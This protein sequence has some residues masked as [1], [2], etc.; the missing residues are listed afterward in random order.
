MP[1]NITQEAAD[2]TRD[3]LAAILPPPGNGYYCVA[4]LSTKRK[5]HV[6][7]ESIDDVVEAAFRFNSAGRDTYYALSTFNERGNRTAANARYC[8]SLFIDIDCGNDKP[9]A[10]SRDAAVALAGFCEANTLPNPSV[11]R[12]GY[13]LHAYWPFTIPVPIQEWV[14]AAK[15]FKR[16]AEASNL[17][18]DYSV[19]ADSARVL[20]VPNTSNYK[21]AS[22][23]A[24][25]PVR[26]V[27]SG[28]PTPF[29]VFKEL[30]RQ[31]TPPQANKPIPSSRSV[32]GL[33]TDSIPN[34]AA[35]KD[36]AVVL[37]L[38]N[39]TKHSFN[40]IV[41]LGDAGCGQIN[42]YLKNA[43]EGGMEPLWRGV[44]STIKHCE[45]G[46]DKALEVSRLHPY[47]D[48]RTAKKY[49]GIKGPY[50]CE[51]FAQTNPGI[52]DKCIHKS[53]IVNPIVLGRALKTQEEVAAVA[54]QEPAQNTS[55]APTTDIF[56]F[57]D[58]PKG[59]VLSDRG[60]G[61]QITD[62]GGVPRVVFICDAPVFATAT[63][64]RAGERYVQFS[65]I[66]HKELKSTV[67][68][69]VAATGRDEVIKSFARVGV[70]V[71]N[72]QEPAF[73]SYIKATIAAAKAKPPLH[74]PTSL[75]WQHDNSFA[76]NGRIF[77]ANGER[78]VPMY[79]FD[80][81]EETMEIR[82]SLDQWRVV[83]AGLMRA[84]RWDITAMML[85]GFASPLMKFTGLNGIT[86]HLCSNA[87]GLGKTLCQRLAS[88]VWGVPDKF[89]VTPNT[90]PIA[91]I[92]R[93]G[94]LGNLPLLVDEI[95]HKG[96]S[97]VEWFPE[98]LSQ[99]SDGR[100]KDRMDSQTNSERRNTTT[101]AS[102]ALMTSNK[103]MLDFLT[104]E[105]IHQ[106]EGEIRRLIEIPF[107]KPLILDDFT[108]SLFYDTLS[109]NY[110]VAGEA[111]ARWL[112]RNHDE[113]R[114]VVKNT[115]AE[116]FKHFNSTGDERFWV[117]G[118][119]SILAAIRLIS[120]AR[121]GII[122]IPFG[123]VA[124]F[125]YETIQH[126][127]GETR[128][129]RRT[130]ADILNEFTKRNYGK[131]VT[132]NERVARIGGMEIAETLDRRDLCGRVE[133]NIDGWL[134]YY[135]EE[136]E[137]KAFCS[138]VSFGYAEFTKALNDQWP[139]RYLRKDLLAGTKGPIMQVRC[140]HIR[141]KVEANELFS[142]LKAANE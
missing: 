48:A 55:A 36:P 57:P 41:A 130:A 138:S 16:V 45:E 93:L 7:V 18:I 54:V 40:V 24:V 120:T 32:P 64:D 82:G 61:M 13:G 39:I 81:I 119:A 67:I 8:R 134:D 63:Y 133:K 87:S 84:E 102:I 107:D 42:H 79:G 97:E 59:F 105:R 35:T 71:A 115:Y 23:G 90:S 121:A 3:F 15:N 38:Q 139:I 22:E 43:A 75:G 73:R 37:D 118:C 116:V 113:A 112:V 140:M 65:Y 19:T 53:K 89:R 136:R 86:F 122:D 20:R 49:E 74:M 129:S 76:F 127:R 58:P 11:V 56:K 108:K 29:E 72:G 46:F 9:Y 10:T 4:E 124:K 137:I 31:H 51:S 141:Q 125:L 123:K 109:E 60:V 47:D 117:A 91:M 5:E 26:I 17:H 30:L 88:S 28:S 100:G 103:H 135:I 101:W 98:F 70:V 128:R 69:M 66:E 27:F 80:N 142:D 50:N 104:A 110:G 77:S 34:Y 106:S 95:T 2:E 78:T 6:Y 68:P 114:E 21:H 132:V 33:P 52:C 94:M 111:Y 12:S 1:T 99:M 83:I 131:L 96:R 92:N 85:I 25:K 44:L 126:M 62:D 14:E